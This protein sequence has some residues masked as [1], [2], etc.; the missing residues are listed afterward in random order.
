[1][2]QSLELKEHTL[3]N[4]FVANTYMNL[5][6]LSF[7]KGDLQSAEQY[8]KKCL[9]YSTNLNDMTLQV[10][11]LCCIILVYCSEEDLEK[12]RD[13][14]ST[15]TTLMG[16][17]S[18]EINKLRYDITTAVISASS[19][20]FDA[21]IHAKNKFEKI[22]EE[23]QLDFDIT[24]TSYFY[25]CKTIFKLNTLF[26]TSLSWDKMNAYLT[27]VQAKAKELHIYSKFF[28]CKI[29]SS[30]FQLLNNNLNMAEKLLYEVIAD[31]KI[32]GFDLVRKMAYDSMESLNIIKFANDNVLIV[33]PKPS[34][35]TTNMIEEDIIHFISNLA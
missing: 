35:T 11:A 18:S 13:Y 2:L 31:T 34:H 20:N 32:R 4:Y 24:I 3:Y 14:H 25:Y 26:G 5:G 1:M 17:S 7:E 29:L 23:N 15:I 9:E 12:C 10:Q 22:I 6:E 19:N 30:K 21:I 16:S 28:I 33:K 27:T 8:Y